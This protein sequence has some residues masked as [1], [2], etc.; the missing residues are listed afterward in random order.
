M[1]SD[2]LNLFCKS[3]FENPA[4]RYSLLPK[5]RAYYF[6]KLSVSYP[7]LL[8]GDFELWELDALEVNSR[9]FK[10]TQAYN[11]QIYSLKELKKEADLNTLRIRHDFINTTP[12]I[13]SLLPQIYSDIDGCTVSTNITDCG[14]VLTRFFD[15]KYLNP[16]LQRHVTALCSAL[17]ILTPLDISQPSLSHFPIC[18]H[19]KHLN[20]VIDVFD[21]FYSLNH[22]DID[23]LD[24]HLFDLLHIA[25]DEIMKNCDHMSNLDFPDDIVLSHFDLHPLNILF[26]DMSSTLRLVDIDSLFLGPSYI[27]LS[28][29]AFRLQRA[30]FIS[31]SNYTSG[32]LLTTLKASFGPYCASA[33]NET[34]MLYAKYELL[35]RISLVLKLNYKQKNSCWNKVLNSLICGVFECNYL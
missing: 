23:S 13:S 11:P 9:N 26:D 34:L 3:I 25:K 20:E 22:V 10:I 19:H 21:H 24:L 30:L 4:P 18:N 33:S 17:D 7:N 32:S 12:Q 28:Y 35:R 1:Y 31:S 14:C 27:A 15:G 6:S 16:S 2:S 8:S 5:E 29:A